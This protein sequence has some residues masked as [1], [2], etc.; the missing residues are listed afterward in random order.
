MELLKATPEWNAFAQTKADDMAAAATA[1]KES[2]QTLALSE[3]Q[4]QTLSEVRQHLQSEGITLMAVRSSSPEEDLEGASF[5]GIYET[6]LGVVDDGLEAAIRTCFTSALDERVVAYKLRSGFDPLDPKIAV[7]IQKQI[8]SEV[9]GVAF[10]LNPL[11]N[12]YDQCVINA[13]LGLGET[14]VDG[15]IT[16]DQWVVDKV[17]N[18]ILE[19][20]PGKKGV[21]VYLKADGGTETR[22]PEAPMA[23]CLS[24]EQALAITELTARVEV[25][26]G[27]PVDIEWT[28]E[29][30]QLSL[31]Q[32]RPITTY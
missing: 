21:A 26:Y 27:K 10:S 11:N 32:A 2:G 28:Y 7:I 3:D 5:A 16:P 22:T 1:V 9:S 29:G 30:E 6:V 25:E 18:A 15:T 17:T 24:D 4:Q 20:T 23:L 19:K 13:S 12:C 14:V 8:A 31:L